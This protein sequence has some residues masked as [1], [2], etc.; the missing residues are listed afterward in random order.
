MEK[1]ERGQGG[2]EEESGD[3]REDE[4][5]LELLKNH[6]HKGQCRLLLIVT[7]CN[8]CLLHHTHF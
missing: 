1:G 4:I 7:V 8:W 6:Y 3:R 5:E 2:N